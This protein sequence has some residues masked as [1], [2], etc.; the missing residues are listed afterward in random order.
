[1]RSSCPLAS[2]YYSLQIKCNQE[3]TH[4][5]SEVK[6]FFLLVRYLSLKLFILTLLL[7]EIALSLTFSDKYSFLVFFFVDTS[8]TFV[9]IVIFSSSSITLSIS[10]LLLP[11][12]LSTL[13][14][15]K[16]WNWSW[17]LRMSSEVAVKSHLSHGKIL[18]LCSFSSCLLSKTR[19]SAVKS[20]C[21]Q[22]KLYFTV[23]FSPLWVLIAFFVFDVK[24]HLS[25]W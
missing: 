16:Q 21:L 9:T 13:V 19:N 25:Q 6:M 8:A 7:L 17:V 20:H 18:S 1:M 11:S 5:L 10:E 24:L 12:P 23:C 15:S 14:S 22:L 3:K 2:G 4:V